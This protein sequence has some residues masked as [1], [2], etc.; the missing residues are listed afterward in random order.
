MVD[1][2]SHQQHAPAN[3][4][5]CLRHTRRQLEDALDVLLFDRRSRQAR[6]PRPEELLDEGRRCSSRWTRSPTASRT[7]PPAGRRNRRRR[8]RRVRARPLTD[9]CAAFCGAARPRAADPLLRCAPEVL[10]GTWEAL[11]TVKADLAIGIA[12]DR[13]AE[14]RDEGA[15]AARVRVRDRAAARWPRGR[16]DMRPSSPPRGRRRRFGA[17]QTPSRSS[18]ARTCCG[19]ACSQDR[20]AAARHGALCRADGARASRPVG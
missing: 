11:V 14:R 6:S 16:G 8:R 10:A 20:R 5:R 1:A 2:R 18:P 7:S 17:A 19:R 3:S 15:R 12:T 13:G 9:L 4:A